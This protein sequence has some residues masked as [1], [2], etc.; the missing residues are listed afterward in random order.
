[1]EWTTL[2]E[3]I[4]QNIEENKEKIKQEIEYIGKWKDMN[5]Q[6]F[7]VAMMEG[8]LTE[9]LKLVIKTRELEQQLSIFRLIEEQR[10]QKTESQLKT[11]DRVLINEGKHKGFYAEIKDWQDNGHAKV[12]L[13]S[14]T[15]SHGTPLIINGKVVRKTYAVSSLEKAKAI[16]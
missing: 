4:S 14:D 10:K 8:R 12:S 1:M 6:S 3:F 5:Y 9:F 13:M 15:G 11:G 2:E 7:D 16:L